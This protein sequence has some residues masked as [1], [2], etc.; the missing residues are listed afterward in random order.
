M[1]IS[2]IS[3]KAVLLGLLTD[4]VGSICVGFGLAI[5]LGIMA[6]ASGDLSPAHIEA[7]RQNFFL[8]LSG[9]IGTTFFTAL[10]GYVA[11]RIAKETPL[12]NSFAVGILSLV[13]AITLA[14]SSAGVSPL[15]KVISGCIATI[16]AALLGGH[17]AAN[18]H[19]I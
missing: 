16:P 18:P 3:A 6:A 19:E 2:D 14:A 11:A 13:L 15:W 7:L 12:A 17:F 1:K 10:G 9:L 4:I 8:R 5:I